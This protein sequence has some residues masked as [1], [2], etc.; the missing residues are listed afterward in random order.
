MNPYERDIVLRSMGADAS[1][2]LTIANMIRCATLRGLEVTITFPPQPREPFYCGSIR[3]KRDWDNWAS[4]TVQPTESG[5][6][7]G[8]VHGVAVD[9]ELFTSNLEGARE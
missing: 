2:Q 3:V 8:L 5:I 7:A 4:Q 1:E 9:I 6:L